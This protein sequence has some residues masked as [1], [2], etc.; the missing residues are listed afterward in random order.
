METC[1]ICSKKLSFRDSFL[2]EDKPI[3]KACLR[4]KTNTINPKVTKGKNYLFGLPSWGLSLIVAIVSFMIVMFL[5]YLLI[6]I[7]KDENIALGIAYIVYDIIIA[8]AC[9][10]I[11][12]NN[13]K[14]IWYVPILCN[15]FGII[16]ALVEP[17]FWTTPMWMVYC[18]GWVLSLIG[19][20]FGVKVGKRSIVN[21]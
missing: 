16:A 17:N 11:C 6:D 5:G 3:C 13:P 18:G 21:K 19:A 8:I 1:H 15:I 4:E 14:S 2:W 10:L 9:F 20:I 12:K 7:L